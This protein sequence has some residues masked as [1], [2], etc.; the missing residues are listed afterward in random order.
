MHRLILIIILCT[1][2]SGC[3]VLKE[4]ATGYLSSPPD[5]T[6]QVGAENTKQSVGVNSKKDTSSKHDNEQTSKQDIQTKASDLKVSGSTVGTV[7][8]L[9]TSNKTST[10]TTSANTSTADSST[11]QSDY[12]SN[13]TAETITADTIIVHHEDKTNIPVLM[14]T[15]ILLGLSLGIL[16]ILLFPL[17]G[18]GKIDDNT[19]S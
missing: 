10:S 18:K 11:T 7:G 8:S 12:K 1:S 2:F 4:V 9:D 14:G 13:I 19:K 3:S 16:F 5:I 17:K 6:A 15:A